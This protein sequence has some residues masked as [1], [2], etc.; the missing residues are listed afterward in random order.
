MTKLNAILARFKN[1]KYF[2][3]QK[4]GKSKLVILELVL[5]KLFLAKSKFYE[6]KKYNFIRKNQNNSKIK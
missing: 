6:H 5:N 3:H 4:L 2:P 1:L